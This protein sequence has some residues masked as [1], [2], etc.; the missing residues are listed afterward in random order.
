VQR[1]EFRG[2]G[3]FFVDLDWV[4]PGYQSV[5]TALK[6]KAEAREQTSP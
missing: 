3:V 2:L 1:E 4:E 5:N 6:K